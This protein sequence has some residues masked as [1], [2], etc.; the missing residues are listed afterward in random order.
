MFIWLCVR[1]WYGAGWAYAW[2]RGVAQR[3]EWCESTFSMGNL[4]RTW[5]AP[6]KQTYAGGSKGSIG[7]LFRAFIDR[8]ISRVIGFIVRSI[9]LFAGAVCSI[10]VFVTGVIFLL[11]WPLLPLLPV[12]SLILFSQGVGV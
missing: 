12:I 1:W 7:T 2:Q 5:F 4:L 11:V 8:L 9:L 10:F 3:L 6:F